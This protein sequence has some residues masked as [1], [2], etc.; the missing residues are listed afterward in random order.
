M[1]KTWTFVSKT[2]HNDWHNRL[3]KFSKTLDISDIGNSNK[4][5]LKEH[6]YGSTSL[7][8]LQLFMFTRLF[9][10]MTRCYD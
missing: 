5:C 8:L 6:H 3:I 4:P 2:G 7:S 9:I 1:D 10:F